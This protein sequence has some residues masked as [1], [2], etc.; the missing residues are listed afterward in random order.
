MRFPVELAVAS[1]S[2]ELPAG[3]YAFEP[4]YD[5][6]R[7]CAHS[8]RSGAWA[9]LHTR[10]GTDVTSRF[11]EIVDAV[12]ALGDVVLDG[13]VV[14]AV[15]IPARLE[16]A[17]LQTAPQRR[18][19][20][21]IG[22]YLLAFD[23]LAADGQDL[24]SSPY[25]QRR[26]VLEDVVGRQGVS[27]VQL[28]PSTQVREEAE[29]WLD[30]AFGEAGIEGVVAKPVSGPYRRGQASGWI[31]IRQL[32]TTEAVIGGVAGS[33]QRPHALV[34]AAHQP[35]TGD[36]W[37]LIGVTSPITAAL[38]AE[39]TP[40]LAFTGWAP[41]RLPGLV[42]GLPGSDDREYWP[43]HP[44]LVVEVATDGVAEQGRW[45]HPVRALRLR[46]DLAPADLA[47]H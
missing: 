42:T 12:A 41:A 37:R 32:V 8:D 17:A 47:S 45:R 22:M 3:S 23:I 31:K 35:A 26:V 38:R 10:V 20:Q 9:R 44:E 7:L 27:R 28:V 21:G 24:R 19:A 18:T 34:L 2:V 46:H 33:R 11:P 13:E 30:P 29:R 16:F 25:S 39:L 6:W 43:V 14:A 15:G 36:R 5:G 1:S 40:Q 4:K